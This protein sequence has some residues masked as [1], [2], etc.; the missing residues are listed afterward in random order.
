M[1]YYIRVPGPGEVKG[2]GR[3]I[4]LLGSIGAEFFNALR[5]T[6]TFPVACTYKVAPIR[7]NPNAKPSDNPLFIKD[8]ESIW[9]VNDFFDVGIPVEDSSIAAKNFAH[10]QLENLVEFLCDA[11]S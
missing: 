9:L 3:W 10:F 5:V 6:Q 4:T 11:S 1:R 2:Q 8:D 7:S